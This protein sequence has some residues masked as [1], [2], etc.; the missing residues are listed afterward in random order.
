MRNFKNIYI[1][2]MAVAM[3]HVASAQNDSIVSSSGDITVAPMPA[4]SRPMHRLDDISKIASDTLER[5]E[6]HVSMGTAITG[7][8]HS[9]ASLFGIS[10][11]VIYRPSER[12]TVKASASL[13]NSYSLSPGGYTLHGRVPRSMAPLR[14]PTGVAASASVSA[15][16]KVND[17][18]M[19]GASLYH[20]GGDL[21]SGAVFNPWFYG[22]MPLNLNATAFSAAMRYRIG[23]DNFLDIHMTFVDDRTGALT[24]YMLGYPYGSFHGF[25]HGSM[26]N[27][28]DSVFDS[29]W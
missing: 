25:A 10:P 14:N 22:D 7:S 6:F 18:L 23:D 5:W 8:R 21:A 15:I 13:L 4:S 3:V 20:V 27:M 16:Y 12:F 2:L 17:R 26:F 28:Y 11:S 19:L 29:Q 24:P 1:L 9:S